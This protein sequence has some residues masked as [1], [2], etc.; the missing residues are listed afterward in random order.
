MSLK[1]YFGQTV[2]IVADNDEIFCG[3]IDDYFYPEDNENNLE[4]IV[5]KTSS[6]NL[7]EFTNEDI[8]TIKII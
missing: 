8:E 5:L 7:Y 4:S 6:G 2:V 3:F 1:Q